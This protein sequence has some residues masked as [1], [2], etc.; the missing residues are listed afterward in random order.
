MALENT[1]SD[2]TNEE[3]LDGTNYD[4][5]HMTIQYLLNEVEFLETVGNIVE[6]P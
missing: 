4:I 3:K 1:I 2:L 6:Q 5:C